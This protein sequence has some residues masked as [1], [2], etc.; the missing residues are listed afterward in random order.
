[1]TT[2]LV[3]AEEEALRLDAED[4]LAA[5]RERFCLP[6]RED[7]E[8]AVY[9]CG[10]SLGLQPR[11][12]REYV[13]AELDRWA[14]EGVAAHFSGDRPW[15]SYHE[16][17]AADMASLVGARPAEVV[18]MNS[19]TVNLH[20]LL[21]SF[22]RPSMDRFKILMEEEAFPSDR[23]AIDSQIRFHGYDPRT[24]KL[25]LRPREGA[26]TV[27]TE[28]V[29]D[30]ITREGRRIALVLLGGV[31][32]VT[33]QALDM[34]RIT[35]A[36]QRVGCT[37]GFDLAHATG[38]I[39]LKLHDWNVDF[40]VWCSYKYLNC[41]PGGVGGAFVHERHAARTDLP[42]FAG[43]WGHDPG[44][45][46]AL[47]P[48][49]R[50]QEGAA[51]WQ[52][53]NAPILSTAACRASLELFAEAGMP[54]LRRKSELL[55]AKLLEWLAAAPAGTLQVVTPADPAARGCQISLRVERA[56]A[57]AVH[58]ALE[59]AGFVCDHREPA[60]IRVAPVPLYNTFHEVWRFAR[61]LVTLL[62]A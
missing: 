29:V 39:P 31:N 61:E 15:Y 23:F 8:P 13:E 37:V 2:L 47:R 7:G 26:E 56:D 59:R 36:A 42:R 11:K 6:T 27:S 34:G 14:A 22:Y 60:I 9:L 38:N 58:E 41:G 16:T 10:H 40:A 49:F 21:V 54:A 52:L 35:A 44:T 55:T 46:F 43:W 50:A 51:G 3:S 57:R 30:L 32:Y 19:L 53:S 24:G 1:M 62:P 17:L 5:F 18:M 45:R 12:A 28:D 20:L 25:L 4:E 48:E 33:G